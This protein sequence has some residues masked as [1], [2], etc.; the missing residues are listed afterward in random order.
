MCAGL[1]P[2][3]IA[4]VLRHKGKGISF[5]CTKFRISHSSKSSSSSDLAD[6]RT[7]M[8]QMFEMISGLCAYVRSLTDKLDSNFSSSV[9]G[10]GAAHGGGAVGGAAAGSSS[11]V[12]AGSAD[13][14][15]AEVREL[16]EREKRK[17]SVIVKGISTDQISNTER[18][19]RNVSD[20]LCPG[21][22]VRFSDIVVIKPSMFRAKV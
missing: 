1:P 7:G 22:Q 9:R 2:S 19:L 14:F 13:L 21:K 10:G 20:F 17:D 12:P 3:T 11:V 15:R 8:N 6:M 16:H 18:V 4:E 5:Q